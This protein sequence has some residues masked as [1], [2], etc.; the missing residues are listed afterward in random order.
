[1]NA[2]ILNSPAPRVNVQ[3]ESKGLKDLPQKLRRSAPQRTREVGDGGEQ[4]A[5]SRDIRNTRHVLDIEL[6]QS[7]SKIVLPGLKF[8]DPALR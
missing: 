7:S 6:T 8:C 2:E 5:C 3:V 1:M 4:V